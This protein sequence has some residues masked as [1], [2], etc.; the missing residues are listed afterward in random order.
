LTEREH[1]LGNSNEWSIKRLRTAAK[2]KLAV[3]GGW[4]KWRTRERKHS[5]FARL[6]ALLVEATF[7]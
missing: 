4:G 2:T 7:S 1:V 6:D 3:R 5:L